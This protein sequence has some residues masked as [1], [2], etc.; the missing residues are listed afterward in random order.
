MPIRFHLDEHVHPA[1]AEGLRRRGI[2]V[3]TTADAG[4]L[5]KPDTDQ[6]AFASENDRVLCTMDADFP[7][8]AQ[9][10]VAHAGIVYAEQ[11][12]RSVGQIIETLVILHGVLDADQMRHHVEII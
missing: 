2:D 8:L 10:G 7:R 11:G 12:R 6:L 5:G 1:V 9:R 3:T 4:L